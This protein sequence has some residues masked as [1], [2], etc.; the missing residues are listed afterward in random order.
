MSDTR[1]Y[2]V[3]FHSQVNSLATLTGYTDAVMDSIV[4][5]LCQANVNSALG[6]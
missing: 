5:T 4:S 6:D 3:Y 1:V 2:S